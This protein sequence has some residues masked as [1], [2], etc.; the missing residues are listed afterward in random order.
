[1]EGLPWIKQGEACQPI[2]VHVY[3][4]PGVR[5]SAIS[6]IFDQSLKVKI[7]APPLNG[8][9]KETLI[10]FVAKIMTI[11]TR[12]IENLQGSR[13]L[14]KIRGIVGYPVELILAKLRV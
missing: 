10:E 5:V 12:Q 9:A 2:K 1:M 14:H 4:Q 13:C 7:A 11:R 3:V 8:A 6:G